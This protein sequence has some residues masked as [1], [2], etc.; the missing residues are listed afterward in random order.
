[1]LGRLG[2]VWP[3]TYIVVKCKFINVSGAGS[4]ILAA[5]VVM[6][7]LA[8]LLGTKHANPQTGSLSTSALT[9]P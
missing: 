2:L 8:T 3:T 1:M 4:P 5:S 6:F 7:A 9:Q